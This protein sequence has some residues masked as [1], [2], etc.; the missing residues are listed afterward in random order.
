MV[1]TA[2][3]LSFWVNNV[4]WSVWHMEAHS[5]MK[6][7]ALLGYLMNNETDRDLPSCLQALWHVYRRGLDWSQQ[8][9]SFRLGYSSVL[10]LFVVTAYTHGCAKWTAL[11]IRPHGQD[12]FQASIL[13]CG[14][15][16]MYTEG[17]WIGFSSV[18][19]FVWV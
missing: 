5:W 1:P 18:S 2:S 7:T 9:Q 17:D 15:F 11:C 19:P 12:G 16:G 13:V 10:V 14:Y 3:G 8:R 6:Q 4:F